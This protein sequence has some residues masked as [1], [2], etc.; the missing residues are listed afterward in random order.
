MKLAIGWAKKHIEIRKP[1]DPL[2][3]RYLADNDGTMM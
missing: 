2:I 3:G 1:L